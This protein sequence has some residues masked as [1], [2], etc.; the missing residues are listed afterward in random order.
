[1]YYA[2]VCTPFGEISGPE[3]TFHFR[4][5]ATL[6]WHERMK[7]CPD[8]IEDFKIVN[9]GNNVR[10]SSGPQI[11]ALKHRLIA[12]LIR[13]R[14]AVNPLVPA[15]EMAESVLNLDLDAVTAE[16]ALAQ[17]RDMHHRL[18]VVLQQQYAKEVSV[19]EEKQK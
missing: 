8:A 11:R 1:M 7:N 6:Y 14:C 13:V 10:L 15:E 16:F 18:H 4:S 9:T 17:A 2:I 3:H 19:I 12:E 5:V